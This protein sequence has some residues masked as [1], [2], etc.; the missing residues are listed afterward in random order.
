MAWP[1]GPARAV[2]VQPEGT[3]AGGSRGGARGSINTEGWPKAL[4]GPQGCEGPAAANTLMQLVAPHTLRNIG[5]GT[6]G[7]LIGY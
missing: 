5:R 6:F 7:S 4:P 3:E 1:S 2:A